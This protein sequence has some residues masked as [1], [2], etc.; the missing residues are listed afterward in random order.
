[1]C[2]H[3]HTCMCMWGGGGEVMGS[4]QGLNV[5]PWTAALPCPAAQLPCGAAVSTNREGNLEGKP[6]KGE[7]GRR[8]RRRRP[9]RL[10]HQS[11]LPGSTKS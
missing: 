5:A 9:C 7:A 10:L 8:G 6:R 2:M 4:R 3:M 11:R 1:M